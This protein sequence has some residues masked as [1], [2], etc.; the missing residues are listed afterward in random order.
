MRS[1]AQDR[2]SVH[3]SRKRWLALKLNMEV[4]QRKRMAPARLSSAVVGY[5]GGLLRVDII[6]ARRLEPAYS[7]AG[8]LEFLFGLRRLSPPSRKILEFSTRRSA[9]AVAMVVLNRMLPQSEK[10]VFVV[11]IVERLWLWRVEMTC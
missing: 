3:E 6:T 7:A 4:W 8:G 10:G 11:M 2:Y 5:P 9:I 1:M